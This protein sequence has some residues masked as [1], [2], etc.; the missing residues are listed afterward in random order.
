VVTDLCYALR[1]GSPPAW[2]RAPT[3]RDNTNRPRQSGGAKP[4]SAKM[5]AV[6]PS[7]FMGILRPF[8]FASTSSMTRPMAA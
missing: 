7:I 4:S 6:A 5:T 1:I 8:R 3:D 2:A